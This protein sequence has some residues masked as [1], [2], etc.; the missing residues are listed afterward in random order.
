MQ[1]ID[2]TQVL[3]Q[4]PQD[5]SAYAYVFWPL[6]N[7]N[8]LDVIYMALGATYRKSYW[9]I[10]EDGIFR[11]GDVGVIRSNYEASKLPVKTVD[12]SVNDFREC[13]STHLVLVLPLLTVTQRAILYRDSIFSH[14][15]TKMF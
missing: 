9:N 7:N 11:A 14:P 12:A 3:P 5:S 4:L 2:T 15:H 1:R 8:T 13:K 10:E 6:R